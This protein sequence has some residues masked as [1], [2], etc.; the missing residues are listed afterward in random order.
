M[1]DIL[2]HI[3]LLITY[4]IKSEMPIQDIMQTLFSFKPK[5]DQGKLIFDRF[6]FHEVGATIKKLILTNQPSGDAIF[7]MESITINET[8]TLQY[9]KKILQ[10]RKT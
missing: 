6:N 7:A 4:A 9:F 2:S 1:K 5:L 8:L 3:S 10:Y